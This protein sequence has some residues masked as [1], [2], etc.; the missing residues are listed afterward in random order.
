MP[1]YEYECA[2]C[3]QREEHSQR[4]ADAPLVN[5]SACGKPELFRV[6]SP[7]TFHLKGGGWY[8]DDYRSSGSGGG[9]E[10]GSGKG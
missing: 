9:G 2:A 10:S 5:C 7:S 3:R 1:I 4:V 8:K 6:I